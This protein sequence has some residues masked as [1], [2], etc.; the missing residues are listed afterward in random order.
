MFVFITT[1]TLFDQEKQNET[2]QKHF[3]IE[4]RD[5]YIIV[6]SLDVPDGVDDETIY[7]GNYSFAGFDSDSGYPFYQLSNENGLATIGIGPIRNAR[8]NT[9]E[10]FIK[11]YEI[12]ST[13]GET[14]ILLSEYTATKMRGQRRPVIAANNGASYVLLKDNRN[15]FDGNGHN[16]QTTGRGIRIINIL[17]TLHEGTCDH[18]GFDIDV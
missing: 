16:W 6:S 15:P 13:D 10:I 18:L 7:V 11:F 5:E 1:V 12:D 2:K 9:F 17:A 4:C 14:L 3:K 8:R